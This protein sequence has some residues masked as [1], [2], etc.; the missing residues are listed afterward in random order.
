MEKITHWYNGIEHTNYIINKQTAL[1]GNTDNVNLPTVK[2]LNT[3]ILLA[4]QHIHLARLKNKQTSFQSFKH[5]LKKHIENEQ[6]NSIQNKKLDSFNEIWQ[7]IYENI[8]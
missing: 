3:C 2:S 7:A 8:S 4:K 1:F 6:Y 5:T